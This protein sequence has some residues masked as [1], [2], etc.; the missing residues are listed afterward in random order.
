[1]YELHIVSSSKIYS[2]TT[3]AYEAAVYLA[4]V[5]FYC[6]FYVVSSICGVSIWSFGTVWLEWNHLLFS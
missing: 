5:S 1:M 3:V 6:Y 4:L 2:W